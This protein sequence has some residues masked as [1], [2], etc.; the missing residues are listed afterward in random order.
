M[1]SNT[2]GAF[3][4]YIFGGIRYLDSS[5]ASSPLYYGYNTMSFTLYITSAPYQNYD[6]LYKLYNTP[7]R[8]NNEKLIKRRLGKLFK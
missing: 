8:K 2:C 7:S 4:F 5:L 6:I 3:T 1:T